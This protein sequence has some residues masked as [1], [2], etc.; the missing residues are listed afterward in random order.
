MASYPTPSRRRANG[1]GSIYAY[2]GR[3]RGALTWT[4]RN[5]LRQRSTVYGKTQAEVRRQLDV[6][7][8][9]LDRGLA[10]PA[11]S[12][13]AEFLASW[14]ESSRQRIRP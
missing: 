1:E 9:E 11:P 13:V 12:S 5:G 4:D 6:L 8:V 3:Y 10:P 14:L 7:R 2:R